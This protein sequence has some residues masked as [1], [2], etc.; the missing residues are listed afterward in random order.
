MGYGYNRE[1]DFQMRFGPVNIH[2]GHHRLN[3]LFSRARQKIHF[4]SSVELK[5]FSKSN[6]EGVRHLMKWF[7]LMNEP[8]TYFQTD[9]NIK[10]DKIIQM[11][12]G[13]DDILSFTKVHLDGGYS[14]TL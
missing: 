2:G 8:N 7:E 13:F 1:R 9:E 10:F 6:N 14:I 12:N 5:D 4:F 11:A 3:V